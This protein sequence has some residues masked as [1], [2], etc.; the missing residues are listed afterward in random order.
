MS[1]KNR[2][3][4]FQMTFSLLSSSS[5]RKLPNNSVLALKSNKP[6]GSVTRVTNA[7]KQRPMPVKRQSQSGLL[8]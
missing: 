7:V 6:A 5:L 3:F 4:H 2:K 1:Y 8:S